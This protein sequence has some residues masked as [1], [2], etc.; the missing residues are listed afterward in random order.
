[1]LSQANHISNRLGITSNFQDYG[2]SGNILGPIS[3]LT[4]YTV[5]MDGIGFGLVVSAT[6]DDPPPGYLFLC[7][8]EHFRT[9]PS[10]FRWPECPA[11][12]SLDQSGVER[13]SM[14]DAARLGFPSI[15][16]STH[17]QGRC[18]DDNVYAGL[19][20]FHQAKGFDPDSQ[21]IARHLGEPLYQLSNEID[22]PFAH[23]EE[24]DSCAEDY[25]NKHFG[26][27]SPV[28]C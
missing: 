21:D 2:A 11:Y 19:R 9:G 20:Q 25:R 22:A 27:I 14:E 8:P 13:L 26:F 23:V 18:W 5:V 12:W 4:V 3:S 1:W 16:L 7:P 17:I 15:S 28:C 10:S 6:S 24:E